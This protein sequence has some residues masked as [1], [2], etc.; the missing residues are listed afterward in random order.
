MA[1]LRAPA[2]HAQPDTPT[3]R[4]VSLRALV[5]IVAAAGV[6]LLAW[7]FPGTI[8]PLLV[9]FAVYAMLDRLVE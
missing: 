1:R 4:G 7:R 8:N 3:E 9:L 5:L 2:R 6:G